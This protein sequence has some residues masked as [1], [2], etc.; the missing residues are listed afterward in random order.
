MSTPRFLHLPPG[1]TP[2]KIETDRGMFAALEALP[3]TGVVERWPAILLPGLTGSKEDFIAVLQTLALSGRR[4]LAVDLRGQYETPGLD[5]PAAYTCAALGA[6]VDALAQRFGDGEPVHLVG[7]S[8][9]G[10]VAREAAIDGRTKFASFTLMGSGPAGI[11]GK[12]AG[13]ARWLTRTIPLSGLEHVWHAGF[14]PEALAAGVPDDIMAF[15]RQRLLSNSPTGL[16]R[17]ADEVVSVRDRTEELRQIEVPT[18][19]LYGEHDDGWPAETQQEMAA[20]LGADCVVV[21]GA[22][23]SPAVEAPETTAA[24]L[25]RFWNE[26]ESHTLDTRAT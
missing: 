7:H 9:G 6:D 4:V 2:R 14:E 18:L 8:F 23:H 3:A 26:A 17:M 10:L 13:H 16:A 12:R 15:L 11:T 21:P 1:V 24:A 22:A 5:D 25:V 19:V 20:A